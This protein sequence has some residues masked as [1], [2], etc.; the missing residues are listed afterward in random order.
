[1][2][3]TALILAAGL[4]MAGGSRAQQLPVISGLQCWFD[5]AQGVTTSGTAVTSWAD[6]SGNGYHATLGAGTPLLATNQ[7]NGRPAIKFQGGNNYLKINFNIIPQQEY[8]VF[9]SGNYARDAANTNQWGGDWGGP[10][11]QQTLNN[12][13]M[14]ES[15]T[16]RMW[17]SNI[18]LAVSQNGTALVQNNA[19]GNPYG[20]ADVY[21]YMVLKVNPVNYPSAYGLIGRPNT[22]W[23]NGYQDVAE[24]IAF[25]RV[26][27][28]AEEGQIGG[29]LA[30]KYAIPTAYAPMPLMMRLDSPFSGQAYPSGSS[31]STTAT[32]V[33]P[34][35]TSPYTVKFFTNTG[36]S[37]VQVGSTQ[38]G[39]G[40]SAR[41]IAIICSSN[42]SLSSASVNQRLGSCSSGR[43]RAGCVGGS[44]AGQPRS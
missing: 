12:H 10:F 29:Y 23:G 5:A 14:F 25:N 33:S 32:V 19:N 39:A 26:L 6:Q 36:G 2:Q 24:I 37:M 3:H 15:G 43:G 4:A 35:G 18:P 17:G 20:M 13:W 30:T 16:K 8:I 27:T 9:R 21:S 31:V 38:S 11:G 42:W 22:G 7:V 1:M 28:T 41:R 44:S 34:L 40:A